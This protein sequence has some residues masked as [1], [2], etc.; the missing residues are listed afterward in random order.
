MKIVK[1]I[2]TLVCIMTFAW[3]SLFLPSLASTTNTQNYYVMGLFDSLF[4]KAEANSKKVE[5]K[6]Q[7]ET[8]KLTDNPAEQIKGKAKQVQ[9]EAMEKIE[10][11]KQSVETAKDEAVKNLKEFTENMQ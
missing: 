3:S 5:G 2:I 10:E 9:G 6:I 1:S 7:E 8:G 4:N 11:V